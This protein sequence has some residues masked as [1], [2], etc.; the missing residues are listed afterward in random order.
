M[1]MQQNTPNSIT[2][3]KGDALDNYFIIIFSGLLG[4]LQGYKETHPTKQVSK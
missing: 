1:D 4:E 3:N 2:A